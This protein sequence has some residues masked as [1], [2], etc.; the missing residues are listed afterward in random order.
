[1]AHEGG[2]LWQLRV[3]L[4]L[5]HLAEPTAQALEHRGHSPS[6]T[7]LDPPGAEV[8]NVVGRDEP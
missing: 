2:G 4:G 3:G 8:S 6:T 1:M 5:D 7:S